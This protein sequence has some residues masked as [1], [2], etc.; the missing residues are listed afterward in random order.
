MAII[1]LPNFQKP[2]WKKQYII[3][4]SPFLSTYVVT[5]SKNSELEPD[6]LS[7]KPC[8]FFQCIVFN[9][10]FFFLQ[11]TSHI[12]TW[13]TGL[14]EQLLQDLVTYCLY[15]EFLHCSLVSSTNWKS[16]VFLF[17]LLFWTL[18]AY[19]GSVNWI[20]ALLLEFQECFIIFEGLFSFSLNC[21]YWHLHL[22]FWSL[23]FVTLLC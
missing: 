12:L 20:A 1:S 18:I 8:C 16:Q 5:S 22:C 4:V 7:E 9:L 11:T 6:F 19:N 23:I 17:L 21:A 10:F 15:F 13:L 2:C 3:L 14:W